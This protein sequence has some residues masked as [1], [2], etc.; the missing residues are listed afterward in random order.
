MSEKAHKAYEEYLK[1]I[2]ADVVT[3]LSYIEWLEQQ[4][5]FKAQPSSPDPLFNPFER[6]LHLLCMGI[7]YVER[8]VGALALQSHERAILDKYMPLD[9]GKKFR[10]AH[11]KGESK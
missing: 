4:Y 8:P 6:D 3:P 11:G 9:R 5:E 10:D 1:P 7:R 2:N